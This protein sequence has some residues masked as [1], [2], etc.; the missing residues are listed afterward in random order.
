MCLCRLLLIILGKKESYSKTYSEDSIFS[1]LLCGST[2]CKR[3]GPHNYKHSI[4]LLFVSEFR[5]TEILLHFP[6]NP[7]LKLHRIHASYPGEECLV[8]GVLSIMG[9]LQHVW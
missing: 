8:T 7:K 9:Q 6:Q 5:H 2:V 1:T 3:Y 4:L